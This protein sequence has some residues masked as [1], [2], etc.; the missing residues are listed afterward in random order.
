MTTG[1]TC[2]SR[3]NER[4]ID[5]RRCRNDEV[6]ILES[7][8]LF[9]GTNGVLR[10]EGVDETLL[11][12]PVFGSG[13]GPFV[14][15]AYHQTYGCTIDAAERLVS[16]T[17]VPFARARSRARVAQHGAAPRL[18]R[19]RC[20]GCRNARRTPCLPARRAG[21]REPRGGQRRA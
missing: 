21:V 7:R 10:Q 5:R 4:R 15:R 2:F 6:S 12:S 11:L 8:S 19:A 20:S 17:D 9:M 16:S 1:L 13:A 3:C 18:G 14:V